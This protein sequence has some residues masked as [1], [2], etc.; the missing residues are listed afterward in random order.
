[1]KSISE[2]LHALQVLVG[3]TLRVWWRTLPGLIVIYTLGWLGYRICLVGAAIITG[4]AAFL[5]LLLVAVGFVSLLA[6][7]I[8][9]LRLLGDYLGI[10]GS[11]PDV[12]PSKDGKPR[13][14]MFD[15]LILTI[16]PFLGIWSM[17]DGVNNAARTLEVMQLAL[18]GMPLPGG[19]VIGA[20]N[21]N[22]TRQYVVMT[23][24][25]VITWAGARFAGFLAQ[26]TG[27]RWLSLVEVLFTAYSLL[28]VI[29]G[30]TRV[31]LRS[32]RWL[33]ERVFMGWVED[34]TARVGDFFS[35][36]AIDLPAPV[37]AVWTAITESFWPTLTSGVVEPM[38]W[39]AM[40]GLAWGTQVVSFADLLAGRDQRVAAQGAA[41]D[42][43]IQ[44][45]ERDWR[46]ALLFIQGKVAGVVDSTIL[47]TWQSFKMVVRA[48][49]AF[50]AAYVMAW[51]LFRA[52]SK[53]VSL[54]LTRLIGGRP[55]EFWVAFDHV[56][57][58]ALGLTT[59]LLRLTLLAVTFAVSL[60]LYG[61]SPAQQARA[62]AETA[63]SA[64][65]PATETSETEVTA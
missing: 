64:F 8:L 43:G 13:S 54:I 16:V 53:V 55:S 15:A 61:I 31:I 39:L 9:S 29:Y 42:Q 58:L 25:M 35:R 50:V 46:G 6:G 56:F 48:G 20:L 59:E 3:Q 52:S 1:M 17:F 5:A 32:Q 28:I 40:A 51:A 19:S 33:R 23:A 63:P 37:D 12:A 36:F 21:P 10:P 45:L 47:P 57:D 2:A 34:A 14:P 44:A 26:A 49:G 65:T 24:A 18:H 38:L 27:R 22:T 60:G 41:A 7:M 30:G 11:L 4:R 62:T